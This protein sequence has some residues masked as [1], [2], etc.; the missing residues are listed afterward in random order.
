MSY[1][2]QQLLVSHL[3]TAYLPDLGRL[4]V[5]RRKMISA[6]IEAIKP[7][8][9]KASYVSKLENLYNEREGQRDTIDKKHGWHECRPYTLP[10]LLHLE[11]TIEIDKRLRSSENDEE[12][13][14]VLK[15]LQDFPEAVKLTPIQP[16][17]NSEFDDPR[18]RTV[19]VRRIDEVKS[20]QITLSMSHIMNLI[21][22][23]A[24][25]EELECLWSKIEAIKNEVGTGTVKEI[26]LS[27][28]GN[29]MTMVGNP[30][31]KGKEDELI[32]VHVLNLIVESD[33]NYERLKAIKVRLE[34]ARFISNIDDNLFIQIFKGKM[35]AG[36]PRVCWR[37]SSSLNDF[38]VKSGTGAVAFIAY[39]MYKIYEEYEVVE[40]PEEKYINLRNCFTIE[41][42]E[43]DVESHSIGTT[44]YNYAN[45]KH[46]EKTKWMKSI[47]E[48]FKGLFPIKTLPK[49]V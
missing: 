19:F 48:M 21:S 25:D 8:G 39:F 4:V 14:E 3:T 23:V 46:T 26:D 24:L 9:S 34:Q 2:P 28:T 33:Q 43:L 10:Q 5:D 37:N 7:I 15:W 45:K 41:S 12:I 11:L 44:Y 1:T 17:S 31:Q 20:V 40:Q 13:M 16:W 47:D 6:Q 49:E 32:F 29:D 38:G 22:V 42:R 30:S 18:N 35:R 36:E 27:R